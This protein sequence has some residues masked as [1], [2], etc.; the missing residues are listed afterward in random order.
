[1]YVGSVYAKGKRVE[2][3]FRVVGATKRHPLAGLYA[4]LPD[5]ITDR[6]PSTLKSVLAYDKAHTHHSLAKAAAN[7]LWHG[8][9]DFHTG[10]FVLVENDNEQRFVKIDHGFSFFNFEPDLVAFD[11]PTGGKVIKKH[12]T[13]KPEFFPTNHYWDI[14]QADKSFYYSPYFIT[15]CEDVCA[16]S[17]EQIE[18]TIHQALQHIVDTFA[19]QNDP[20]NTQSA[21]LQ[22]AKRIGMPL[23]S[24]S[25]ASTQELQSAIGSHLV[26]RL[27]ERQHALQTLID[28]C[29][30]EV[31]KQ[32]APLSLAIEQCMKDMPQEHIKKAPVKSA[33]K[34]KAA[35][36]KSIR[37]PLLPPAIHPQRSIPTT[38]PRPIEF[39]DIKVDAEVMKRYRELRRAAQAGKKAFTRPSYTKPTPKSDQDLSKGYLLVLQKANDLGILS[40]DEHHQ[41]VITEPYFYCHLPA[42]WNNI[43]SIPNG[44]IDQ[45]TFAQA[46][47]QIDHLSEGLKQQ[48]KTQV[49]QNRPQ[50]P[51]RH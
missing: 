51:L 34:G 31:K 45:L 17:R 44:K 49:S 21:L 28:T 13:K 4:K 22:F 20:R 16:I 47:H 5:F 8:D 18:A 24:L 11:D 7:A 40:V 10:N 1:M 12:R 2:D 48:C 6:F 36:K 30:K 33:Q 37:T 3:A 15:A 50:P 38:H 42:P 43:P 29:T 39:H 25:T 9:H 32:N 26:D 14:F 27:V 35:F 23:T 41:W 46:M 19:V